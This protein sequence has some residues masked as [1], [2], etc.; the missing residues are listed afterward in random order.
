[1]TAPLALV[2]AAKIAVTLV[3]VALPLLL[4]HPCQL[5]RLLGWADPGPRE[6]W[7]LWRLY[8]VALL[9][10]L[11]GYGVALSEVLAGRLP[12]GLLLMAA[13]SNLGAA[14]LLVAASAR[15]LRGAGWVFAGFGLAM[16]AGLLAPE[17]MLRPL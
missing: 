12:A 14:A 8:G 10:L 15:L 2:L 4:G 16:L 7:I 11:V 17:A 1:M 6:T 9:A 5:A 3:G 13:L